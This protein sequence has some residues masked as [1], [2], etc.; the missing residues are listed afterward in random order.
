MKILLQGEIGS[1]FGQSYDLDV[2]TTSEAIVALGLQLPGFIEFLNRDDEYYHITAKGFDTGISEEDL[3]K[4]LTADGYVIISPYVIGGG[5]NP[6][7]SILSGAA[8]VAGSFLLPGV[9]LLG[10]SLSS[11]AGLIGASMVLN[12]FAQL[13]SPVQKAKPEQEQRQSSII[14]S[15]GQIVGQGSRVPIV[16]GELILNDLLPISQIITNAGWITENDNAAQ[17]TRVTK[18]QL[19]FQAS[20]MEPYNYATNNRTFR[21]LTA[22]NLTNNDPVNGM[23]V[24]SSPFQRMQVRCDFSSS[25]QGLVINTAYAL[26][27]IRVFNGVSDYGRSL[28]FRIGSN[29]NTDILGFVEMPNVGWYDFNLE[30][31]PYFYQKKPYFTFE[32]LPTIGSEHI[33]VGEIQ[34]FGSLGLNENVLDIIG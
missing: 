24:F 7:M 3:S 29:D 34:L 10:V 17:Y 16:Y 25:P 13:I 6:L 4:P 33:A 32:F 8:L 9:S 5:G 31:I 18:I 23:V 20:G 2:V 14:D 30:G 28:G 19:P 26:Q 27:R 21:P 11:A 1:R 22:A 15:A 12:G